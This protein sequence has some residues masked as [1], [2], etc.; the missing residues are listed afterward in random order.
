MILLCQSGHSDDLQRIALRVRAFRRLAEDCSA[1][2]GT[3]TTC[4]GLLCESGHSDDLQSIP[5]SPCV[6][7]TFTDSLLLLTW[8]NGIITTNGR[9]TCLSHQKNICSTCRWRGYCTLASC[10]SVATTTCRGKVLA[11]FLT[12]RW[13]GLGTPCTCKSRN[14]SNTCPCESVVTPTCREDRLLTPCY[15]RV[16]SHISCTKIISLLFDT[17]ES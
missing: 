1:S 5:A 7:M 3:P 16:I 13:G 4:R 11:C 10:E 14:I 9:N 6:L 8:L 15:L 17:C 2:P 12:C